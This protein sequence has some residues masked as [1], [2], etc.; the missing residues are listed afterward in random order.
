MHNLWLAWKHL[1]HRPATLVLNLALLAL[2]TGLI[3][4]VLLFN[5]MLTDRLDRNLAGIDMVIGAK[6]SPL[7]L[8]LAGMYH[9]DVP[10]GNIPLS[11]AAPFLNK[12]HPL[13]AQA[14]P[15]S[16]GD[17][18][19]GYRIVGTDTSF[20]SLYALQ[21]AE[22]RVFE[23]PL[24][25]VAG[26]T[27]AK[28]LGLK[29]GD[30]F[31]SIHGL[32]DNP[33]LEHGD[34]EPFRVSGI[35][36]PSGTVADQLLLCPTE[37]VWAVHGDH[38][39]GTA[40]ATAGDPDQAVHDHGD[41]D[42][43]D[44]AGHDHADHDHSEPA[45]GESAAEETAMPEDDREITSLLVR[46]KMRNH[47]TLNMPRSINENTDL[48][49]ASPAIELNRLYDMLGAGAALLRA[50]AWIILGVSG[51]SIFVSLYN[52]M[53]ARRYELALMRV[54]G[55]SPGNLFRLVVLEGFLTALLGAV[56]GLLLAHG[57]IA[58]A[59]QVLEQEWRHGF[60]PWVFLPEEGIVFAGTLLFG[61]LAALIP[62]LQA[63]RVDIGRTL[64]E[65]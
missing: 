38:D 49:A 37:G 34:S 52:A 28:R 54:M 32:D 15:L 56:L 44:H 48:Q 47:L 25:V 35:L 14:V 31:R 16:L 11:A 13:I 19:K 46:F 58:L 40:E 29:V 20:L 36:A 21:M 57:G 30:T 50:L 3:A 55:S 53:K 27:A 39:H 51:L 23:Q 45:T 24:D 43:G 18:Y 65:G 8:I 7:Q 17:S 60:D 10:T 61:M 62:A 64:T 33:D 4:A 42:H 22:G 9:I 59:G 63:R 6:G 1:A 2:S 41:H 5:R 26:A 12:R